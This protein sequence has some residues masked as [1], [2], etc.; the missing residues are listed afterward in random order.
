M[1]N[2]RTPWCAVGVESDTESI[3]ATTVMAQFVVRS[4]RSRQPAIRPISARWKWATTVISS[5]DVDGKGR[6]TSSSGP[7]TSGCFF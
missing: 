5:A 2:S 4:M 7:P 6:A 1:A 3:P